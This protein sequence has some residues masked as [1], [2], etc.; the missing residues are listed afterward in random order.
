M[1]GSGGGKRE[2]N[3]QA[4]RAALVEAARLC[5]LELGYDAVTVRDIV[6]RTDLATGTFYNYFQDKESLFREILEV[7]INDINARMHEVRQSA[8]SIEAFIHGAYLALF[9]KIADEPDF[10]GLILRNEHAVR[11][12]FKDTIV[13]LPMRA[14]KEDIR[15]AIKR[16]VF[17]T[18]D[19]D[20]LAAAFYGTGFEIGRLMVERPGTD[21]DTAAGFATTLLTAGLPAFGNKHHS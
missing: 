17:P 11:S 8:P 10:F 1:D 19:V 12:L 20:M 2:Q 16:G 21:P 6:R 15:D 5:F 18:V 4:N 7:R 14:L 9:R 13:G 3:K